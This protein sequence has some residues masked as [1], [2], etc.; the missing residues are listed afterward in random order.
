M[1]KTSNKGGVIVKR[2]GSFS[3]MAMAFFWLTTFLLPGAHCAF[4]M[5]QGEGMVENTKPP[6][7]IVNQTGIKAVVQVN[8]ADTMPN[9]ISKQVMAVKNLYD[10]YTSI[11]M[12]PGKDYE[13]VMIFRA[14]GAQFLLVDEAY[15]LKVKQPHIKGNPNK[16][17]IEVLQGAGVK[18]YECQVSMALK[19]YKPDDLFRF[20]R[21]VPSGIGAFIDFEISGYV[22]I[23]P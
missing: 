8:Y 17:I 7:Q 10:Q 19:G 14:D 3:I 21:V 22:S 11:G 12:K 5:E 16:P 6:V 20:S 2:K 4:G 13:I 1:E 15:D 23:T 18:M 9:G